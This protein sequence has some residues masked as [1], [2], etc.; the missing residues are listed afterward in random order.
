Q[1]IPAEIWRKNN[2]QVSKV[3]VTKKPVV[4]FV[5][6]P[7]QQTADTDLSNNA[8]PRQPAASRFELFQQQAPTAPNPMQQAKQ[9]T[10]PMQKQEQKPVGSG[11]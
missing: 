9:A 11:Q 3:M 6:D 4:S 1:T 8:F 2:A 7:Y 5:L 10:S